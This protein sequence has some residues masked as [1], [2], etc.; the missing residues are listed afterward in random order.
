MAV[1]SRTISIFRADPLDAV[2]PARERTS[3]ADMYLLPMLVT[4]AAGMLTKP[5]GASLDFL[6]PVSVIATAAVLWLYRREI[7]GLGWNFDW[8]ALGMGAV[9]FTIWIALARWSGPLHDSAMAVA[10][11]GLPGWKRY[12]W[13]VFRVAGAVVSVPIAEELCFRGYLL[14][15][16]VAEDFESVDPRR[17]TWLSFVLSSILFG[18]LHRNWI[19]GILAGMGFA[20]VLY[21]R[22][23]L[24]DAIVAHSACNALLAAYV[25]ATGSWA[26]WN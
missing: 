21:R 26:L 13:L 17:F 8:T 24:T 11:R 5:F 14:R 16:L 9:V 7:V 3:S 2:P 22:G 15:K 1:S 4:L 20:T 23:R 19:A 10:L 18:L 12:G 6:Y 25:L